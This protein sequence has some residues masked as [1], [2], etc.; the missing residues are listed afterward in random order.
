MF[1]FRSLMQPLRGVYKVRESTVLLNKD[2]ERVSST[3]TRTSVR[4]MIVKK[5]RIAAGVDRYR[6]R[7]E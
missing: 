5:D 2:G 6:N 1:V 3:C 4:A 7:T